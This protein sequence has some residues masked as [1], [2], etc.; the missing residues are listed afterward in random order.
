MTD[1]HKDEWGAA[2]RATFDAA[3]A[4]APDAAMEADELRWDAFDDL[5][6]ARLRSALDAAGPSPATEERILATLLGKEA[7]AFDFSDTLPAPGPELSA[8]VAAP[9]VESL[10]D[11]YEEVVTGSTQV[12]QPIE[13]T[14]QL[15]ELAPEDVPS[16]EEAASTSDLSAAR[17]TLRGRRFARIPQRLRYALATLCVLAFVS[18][19]AI[20]SYLQRDLATQP[21]ILAAGETS[22][23]GSTGQRLGMT[24]EGEAYE[25]TSEMEDSLDAD[26][27]MDEYAP[28]AAAEES[29]AEEAGSTSDESMR[30]EAAAADADAKTDDA[31]DTDAAIDAG[32]EAEVEE[33]A[34]SPSFATAYPEVTLA[35]GTVLNVAR[36]ASFEAVEPTAVGEYVGEGVG[37][38]PE[39]EGA[40]AHC[41]VYR[42][43]AQS[44]EDDALYVVRYAGDSVFY[45][46]VVV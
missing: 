32:G 26:E 40:E 44:D 45:L 46:A 24:S 29:V 27:A 10:S 14:S 41:E 38:N 15:A 21:A 31:V 6:Q 22:D 33:E 37:R 8:D 11:V 18:S 3:A 1:E 4:D 30:D 43:I 12:M 20:S 7:P 9:P 23:A 5:I 39:T 17:A 42:L 34:A 28:D 36:G 2:E 13:A 35:D 16:Y 19:I 25:A